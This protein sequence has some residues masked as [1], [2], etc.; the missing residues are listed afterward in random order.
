MSEFTDDCSATEGPGETR[1]LPLRALIYSSADKP[2]HFVAH[3]LE[4]DVV[5]VGRSALEAVRLL[6]ELVGELI[7]AALADGTIDKVLHPAPAD[8][9]EKFA[10]GVERR[11]ARRDEHAHRR[12]TTAT[13]HMDY[14]LA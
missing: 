5:A 1:R 12:R 9:W 14:A 11:E 3:C 8:R 10:Q 2:G 4:L 6:D 13:H 7:V